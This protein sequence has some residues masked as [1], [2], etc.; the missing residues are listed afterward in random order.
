MLTP[1]DTA[2]WTTTPGDSCS[3]VVVVVVVGDTGLTMLT[4]PD[5][6]VVAD[7]AV[8][9]A[10]M[11]CEPTVSNV[12]VNEPPPFVNVAFAGRRAAESDEVLKIGKYK[13]VASYGGSSDF[14]SGS[15]KKML[16]V[17][18]P[19]TRTVLSPSVSKVI[20]RNEQVARLSVAVTPVFGGTAPSGK[21][22][23]TSPTHVVC[24]ISLTRGGG[25]CTL[26]AKML[27]HGTYHLVASYS[28]SASYAR[29]SSAKKTFTV[30]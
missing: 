25:S 10:E 3:G 15:A 4:A 12:T 26:A 17:T 30:K 14:T 5:V 13:V 28:G 11:V 8:S 2:E 7:T 27:G 20:V 16:S 9:V 23:I 1:P 21:V 6:P 22:T 29:S 19:A 24:V 18:E